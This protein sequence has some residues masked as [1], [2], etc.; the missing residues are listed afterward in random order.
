MEKNLHGR[1][2]YYER[3]VKFE[4]IEVDKFVLNNLQISNLS[5]TYE[6]VLLKDCSRS[7]K[8]NSID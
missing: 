6:K 2:A 4:N 7:E 3:N 8:K 5:K 1:C